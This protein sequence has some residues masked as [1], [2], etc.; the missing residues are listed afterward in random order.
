M[1]SF[2][3]SSFALD[4][5][6]TWQAPSERP[7]P[8]N[9]FILPVPQYTSTPVNSCGKLIDLNDFIDAS[10]SSVPSSEDIIFFTPGTQILTQY[11]DRPVETLR[12]GDMVVTRDQGL[13]PIKWLG[14]RVVRATGHQAPVRLR[15]LDETGLLVS[16]K[17]RVLFTGSMS[18]I[19]FSQSEILVEAADLVNGDDVVREDYEDITYIHL[20]LDHH[21]VIYA[22][23]VA[24]ESLYLNETVLD[25]FTAEQREEIFDVFP[26]IRS[27]GY[28][29]SG[30]A[31]ECI[32]TRQAANLLARCDHTRALAG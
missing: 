31:R 15:G 3:A 29:H 1:K 32:D 16:P 11:G 18:E 20:V 5:S 13:R 30:T 24:T 14:Q 10:K 4:E 26:H 9:D 23:G 17:H 7:Q 12:V 22:N 27:T 21:E 2:S 6:V 19:L 28:T 8:G 25:V